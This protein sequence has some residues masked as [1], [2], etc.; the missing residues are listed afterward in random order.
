MSGASRGFSLVE[1]A[2]VMVLV[3]L[4]VTGLALPAAKAVEQA[5]RTDARNQ[6]SQIREA[7]LGFAAV[8]GRLPCPADAGGSLPALCSGAPANHGFVPARELGLDGAVDD[9]GRLLD[10]WGQPFR[11]AVTLSNG[12]AFTAPDPAGQMR[13]VGMGALAPHLFVCGAAAGCSWGTAKVK[14]LP[15]LFF[16]TGGNGVTAAPSA[17]EAE[18]LDG[19]DAFVEHAW[20]ELDGAGFDDLVAWISPNVLYAKMIA[21]GQLP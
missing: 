8:H 9:A 3:G 14:S 2:I 21:A 12:G 20:S 5:R 10:P 4:L 16:S 18:N 13:A 17:D 6:L 7:L 1:M 15:V 19:N 11:Y